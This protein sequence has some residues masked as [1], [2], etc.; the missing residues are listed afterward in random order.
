MPDADGY[1]E[2]PDNA[3]F[4]RVATALEGIKTLLQ[5]VAA[6]AVVVLLAATLARW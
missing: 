3:P 6:A 2:K 4:A 1:S 5:A